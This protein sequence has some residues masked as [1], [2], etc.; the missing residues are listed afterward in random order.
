MGTST[1]QSWENCDDDI[2]QFI[3]TFVALIE[4]FL[5]DCL[6]GIYLHGSL[7]MGSYYRPKSDIDLFIVVREP[8][9]PET[10]KALN[11]I[12]AKHSEKRPTTSTFELNVITAE[13]AKRPALPL[14][15]ELHYSIG[16]HAKILNDEV[17]YS[18]KESDVDLVAQLMYAVQY[19]ICL[20]GKPVQAVFGAISWGDFMASVKADCTK[21]LTDENVL[22]MPINNVLNICRVL[23]LLRQDNQVVHSKDEGAAWGI[24][25]L[26][27]QFGPLIQKALN[28]YH[29]SDP[30]SVADRKTGG[31]LWDKEDLLSF[32]DYARSLI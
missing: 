22:A 28:T 20:S 21:L 5:G 14:P 3:N 19:G 13:T 6:V 1:G 25:N 23:Q 24:A 18:S 16:W 4:N 15:Y 30:V 10:A 17:D 29:S 26:P 7:T 32:R 31:I 8:L 27:A 12:I 2:K 9:K 11:I